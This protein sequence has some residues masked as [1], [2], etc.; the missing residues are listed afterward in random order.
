M[1]RL[2]GRGARIRD[3]LIVSEIVPGINVTSPGVQPAISE[4]R[5]HSS[6]A[7]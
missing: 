7:A 1:V 5:A 6:L 3:F 2:N 4:P